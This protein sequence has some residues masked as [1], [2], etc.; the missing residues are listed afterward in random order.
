M[1]KRGQSV[2]EYAILVTVVAAALIAM[3]QYVYRSMNSKLKD[4]QDELSDQ[5]GR[6]QYNPGGD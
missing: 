2:L 5:Y 4:V 1:R 6:N 3:Q